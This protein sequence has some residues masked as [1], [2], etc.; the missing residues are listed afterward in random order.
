MRFM[1]VDILRQ[2][3]IR[4]LYI[5]HVSTI[6]EAAELYIFGLEEVRLVD[7]F[8]QCISDLTMGTAEDDFQFSTDVPITHLIL[9]A[10]EML[11]FL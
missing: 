2:F 10:F 3:E 8:S 7:N 11:S 9:P 1:C 5:C 4:S 6:L